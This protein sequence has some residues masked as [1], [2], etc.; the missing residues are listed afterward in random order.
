MTTAPAV[1]LTEADIR[2][3][4]ARLS[5]AESM[6]AANMA[7][8]EPTCALNQGQRVKAI[9]SRDVV[10]WHKASVRVVRGYVRSRR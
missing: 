5:H 3:I 6:D 9:L 10:C 2:Q 8:C 1:A 4:A 7:L